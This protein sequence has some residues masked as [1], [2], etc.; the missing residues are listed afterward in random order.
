M[1]MPLSG[2]QKEMNNQKSKFPAFWLTIHEPDRLSFEI[3]RDRH[4]NGYLI[5]G[6]K[7]CLGGKLQSSHRF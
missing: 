7:F 5:V 6:Y 4:F 1:L 3:T 2:K